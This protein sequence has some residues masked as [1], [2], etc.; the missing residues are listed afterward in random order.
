VIANRVN[1]AVRWHLTDEAEVQKFVFADPDIQAAL[2][3]EQ[4]LWE[5]MPIVMMQV[6][7]G[8]WESDDGGVITKMRS[9]AKIARLRRVYG[10]YLVDLV[11]QVVT[12]AV[13]GAK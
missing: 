11:I 12:E 7:N 6:I 8:A 5:V 13:R 4:L 2:N 1:T 9:K 10:D 3:D